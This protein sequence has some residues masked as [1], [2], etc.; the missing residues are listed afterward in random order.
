MKN[1]FAITLI[2]MSAFS[3]IGQEKE[4][5][6]NADIKSVTIYNSSAEINYQKEITLP[7]GKSTIVF[8][9]LSPFIIENTIGVSVSNTEID[10]ITITEKINYIKERKE[11]NKKVAFLLDSISAIEKEMGQLKCKKNT[12]VIEKGLLFKDESIGGVSKGVAVAEIEKASAFFSKRY[13][14]LEQELFLSTEKE[15]M[16]EKSLTNYNNEINELSKNTQN[17][18]SEIRVTVMNSTPKKATFS[19]KFLTEKGGWAPV[20]D[21]KYQDPQSPLNLIFR[22]NVF[23]ATGTSWEDVNIVL[24]TANPTSGFNT[25]SMNS[26][27][28]TKKQHEGAVQFQTIEVANAIAEY[29]IKHKY[30]IPS[31]SKPYLIDVESYSIRATYN[32]LLIPKLDAFGFLMA[33]IPD[34]NKYNLIPGTTNIY[35]K[36]SFMGKT[37]LNTY[38]ENDTLSLYLGKDKNIQ[39]TRKET[40]ITNE[41]NIVGNYYIDKTTTIISIKNNSLEKLDIQLLDQVP[42]YADKDNVKF[43][44]QGIEQAL[45]N[46]NEGMLTWNFSLL[47]NDSK[48]IEYKYEIKE[49]K[50]G[51]NYS[52]P[53]KKKFRTISCPTF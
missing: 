11:Q 29:E 24:S 8:T 9:D 17:A 35:N 46:K 33:K 41:K 5:E 15:K 44:L 25:P 27:S 19:F 47:S 7:Q 42:V 12:L 40:S 50:S 52:Y 51:F 26:Q 23:N 13:Y 32:Y 43:H 48:T 49:P 16:L 34:W 2:L 20:Y 18:C 30:T 38:A 22:A 3:A 14:E 1:L 28:T 45:Y 53:K 21:F 6:V 39:S 4:I 31:D 36:G 10:I 37:F